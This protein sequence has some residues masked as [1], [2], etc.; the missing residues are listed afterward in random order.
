MC[1]EPV[2]CGMAA[3]RNDAVYQ[4]RPVASAQ[5]GARRLRPRGS[6][7]GPRGTCRHRDSPLASRSTTRRPPRGLAP[8]AC[9]ALSRRPEC[10][11]DAIINHAGGAW[12]SLTARQR[13]ALARRAGPLASRCRPRCRASPAA[14]PGSTCPPAARRHLAPDQDLKSSSVPARTSAARLPAS[15]P[16]WRTAG[17]ARCTA[18]AGPP[19]R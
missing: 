18:P 17:S 19:R 5:A 8:V 2:P 7:P 6:V 14:P 11:A 9:C 1:P 13:N 4:C 16:A 12:G 3:A 10:V 15:L